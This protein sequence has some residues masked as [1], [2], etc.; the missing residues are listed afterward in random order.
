MKIFKKGDL[1]YIPAEVTLYKFRNDLNHR[2]VDQTY[3]G[4]APIQVCTLKRP[5]NALLLENEK[6]MKKYYKILYD[7]E[8]W[9]VLANDIKSI[10]RNA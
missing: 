8:S 2:N 4:P 7:S 3:I 10:G 5:V 9:H 1:I 6:H